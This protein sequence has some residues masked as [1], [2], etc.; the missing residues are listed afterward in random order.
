[1]SISSMTGFA[2]GQG[3]D[4][5][6]SWVWEVKSV[7]ARGLD[8]RFR[9]PTGFD[10]VERLAR[11]RVSGRFQRGTVSASLNVTW[12][13]GE[14]RYRINAELLDQVIGLIPDIR[15]RLPDAAPPRIDGLLALRGIIEQDEEEMTDEAREAMVAAVVASFDE[16]LDA[17]VEARAEEGARLAEALSARLD[18]IT[19]L[20][21]KAETLASA[22]ADFLRQRLREQVDTLLADVP[23]LPEERLAQEVALL[24]VKADVREELDRLATH[25]AAARDL[26]KQ[27]DGVGRRFD[28]LCQEFNREANTLCSK[29]A[30]M[31]LKAVGMELKAVIDQLREQIQ[32]IE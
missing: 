29:S 7:N 14:V 22:Q 20:C 17:L 21:A 4:A 10:G 9:L 27:G 12:T 11:D 23:A 13:R 15:N 1:M 24:L 5:L 26:L 16:A 31:E 32:N 30:D 25:V 8:V 28:F 6:C 18:E 3:A 19:A 2:R